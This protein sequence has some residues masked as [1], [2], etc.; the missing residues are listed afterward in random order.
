MLVILAAMALGALLTAAAV[1]LARTHRR[2]ADAAAWVAVG[3]A[4]ELLRADLDDLDGDDPNLGL[5]HLQAAIDHAARRRAPAERALLGRYGG[6]IGVAVAFG[7]HMHDDD[8][9]VDQ[10]AV[11]T[12]REHV[13]NALRLGERIEF[14]LGGIAQLARDAQQAD[15][16][17]SAGERR[18]RERNRRASGGAEIRPPVAA[19]SGAGT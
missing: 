16:W 6:L 7:E 14:A 3:N 19:D 11:A 13:R 4:N 12:R 1:G 5:R 17:A 15:A 8:G 18:L 9:T 10:R 2:C